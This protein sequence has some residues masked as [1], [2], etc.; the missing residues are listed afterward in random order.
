[1]SPPDSQPDEND[2]ADS[3]VRRVFRVEPGEDRSGML[4]PVPAPTGEPDEEAQFEAYI[5]RY[6]PQ[7]PSG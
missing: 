7:L 2:I 1:M 5:R 4:L 6:F 3:I